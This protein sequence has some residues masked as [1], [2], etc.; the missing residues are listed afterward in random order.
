MRPMK[1]P[2]PSRLAYKLNRLLLRRGVQ[3]FLRYGVPILILA[4]I[5]AIWASDPARV[6][7]AKDR[8][9]AVK[10]QIEERPEFMVRMMAVDDASPRVSA[11]IRDVLSLD[12]PLSSFD[13]DLDALRLRVESLDAVAN[14]SVHIRAGGVLEVSIVERI[15]V[16]VWR[17]ED[18]LKL[19]DAEGH[20]VVA[21]D[22]RSSRPDLP[23]ILGRGAEAAVFEAVSL[24]EMSAPLKN[25]LRGFIRVGERRWDVVLDRDQRI[26]LPEDDPEIAFQ[27]V[28]ALDSAQDL[29]ER[30]IAA[31]DFR[32]PHRPVIRVGE[33][34]KE[35]L[36]DIEFA[37]E[38]ATQ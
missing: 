2:A 33:T 5:G 15:P 36:Y 34:A 1:D 31:I 8:V 32:N 16:A 25:R 10:R 9:A 30:D 38:G 21:L 35:T 18:G 12:F 22:E 11:D 13:L 20:L 4:S 17:S 19:V 7:D 14:A 29:L 3:R 23:L 6:Q 37:G 26:K 24:F 27:R 28:M